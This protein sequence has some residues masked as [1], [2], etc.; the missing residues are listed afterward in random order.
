LRLLRINEVG[1]PLQAHA[2]AVRG[3]A[4]GAGK[5]VRACAP[6]EKHL[7]DLVGVDLLGMAKRRCELHAVRLRSDIRGETH[8]VR[9]ARVTVAV[10]RQ[11][12]GRVALKGHHAGGEPRLHVL[13]FVR[14][15]EVARQLRVGTFQHARPE[16]EIAALQ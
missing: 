15:G 14:I 3:M 9:H 2:L 13:D 11:L 4:G 1:K 16:P 7:A 10:A 12:L 5:V 6:I 8:E